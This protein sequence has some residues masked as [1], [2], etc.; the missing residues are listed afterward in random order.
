MPRPGGAAD[1]PPFEYWATPVEPGRTLVEASAGTGKTFAI[2]GLVLRLVLEGEWLG[3]APDLRRLLVVTFTNAATDELRT[4]VRAALRQALAVARGQVEPD[5]LTRPLAELLARDGAEGRLLA[6]LDRVDEAG[7][8]TIHGFCRRVLEQAAFESGTP[9]DLDFV[10]DADSAALRARAAADAWARLTHANPLLTALA[11]HHGRTPDALVAHHAAVADFPHVRVLPEAPDLDAA[12]DAL[13]EARAALDAAWDAD[14][15]GALLGALDWNQDAPL[16]GPGGADVLRRVAAFAGGAEPDAIAAVALCTAEAVQKKATTRSKAQKAAVAAALAHPALAACEAVM[17]AARAVDLAFVR[18]FIVEVEDQIEA[19]KERR[20]QLTFG[21]LITRLHDALHDR[22]TGPALAET[23]GRQFSVALIDEFQDTDPLQYAIFKTAFAGRPLYFVGD[24]KQAIYAFRGA[25]VHAYLG[26][27]READRR[28]TLGT[29][30]RSAAG[31][32]DAVNAVFARPERAFLFD[33]IPFRPVQAARREPALQDGGATPPLVWWPMPT[34][35]DG[36]PMGKGAVQAEI[37]AFVAAEVRRLLAEARLGD[38]ALEP[39]DIAV[40]V[41]TRFQA[42]DVQ[43]AL[44]GVGVPSVVSRSNDVRDSAAMA[45]VELVLRAVLR[46][47]DERARRAALSTELW[48]WTAREIAGLDDD[49][50][51]DAAVAGRL[52]EWQRMWRRG[53]VL[54]VLVAFQEAEGVL[55]R[56]L[57]RPDGERWATDLRHTAELL[58][59]IE[60]AGARSPDDL[61]HWLR[62]R[63]EQ[64]LPSRGM[65]ELR[66][67]RDAAAV[68]IT[69]HHNAKGLEYEV[70]F[71][72]YLWAVSERAYKRQDPVLARTPDGVVYDLGSPE[73][74]DHDR[75]RQADA[76]AEGVRTAYVAL[77]RARERCYVVWGPVTSWRTRVDNV[78][79]L[80]YLLCGHDAERGGGLADHVE[81]ARKRAAQ[82]DVLAP[83]HALDPTGRLMAVVDPPSLDDAAP[84]AP[85]AAARGGAAL[86]LPDDARRRLDSPWKRASFTAWTAGRDADGRGGGL[87]ASDEPAAPPEARADAEPTGLHAFAAGAGPGTCLHEVLQYAKW[88]DDEDAAEANR[89]TVA[90][91]LERHGLALPRRHRA[92]IDPAAEVLALVERVAT[93]PLLGGVALRD[94][95]AAALAPEWDFTLPLARVAPGA[96]ADVFRSHGAA[97]F[98]ADYADALSRLSPAA[99]DG[100]LVGS[101]DLVALADDRWWVV[102]WKSNRLG[103][104]ASAYAPDALQATML[105]HHYGLQLHLYTLGLHRYLRSRLGAAYAYETHVGGAA[106]AFL[107]GLG[108]AATPPDDAD[109]AGR[110]GAAGLFRHRPSAAL[111]EALDGLLAG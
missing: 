77:T 25:D 96:L 63:T 18:R 28:F 26:A 89:E 24:P 66:L 104:D 109:D 62:H 52:R 8:F 93:A 46:A 101:A 79:S 100:F 16:D 92:R 53:G 44:Q 2:A 39:G 103:A 11:L 111:V 40:L 47:G 55:D 9:F 61:L 29:N 67:E 1:V 31:L 73:A 3:A 90:R 30:W 23:I 76:L 49:P 36:K 37:P 33:D 60:R 5:D 74:D 57:A 87:A 21:D 82:D 20:G 17:E 59:E 7:I 80:G 64:A 15:V 19:I 65:K 48:G 99:V 108:G 4:R 42:N 81:A 32:V 22:A 54:G 78:S 58:H 110:G 107:R 94:V 27:Q 102:D 72:P 6:A 85:P 35:E 41:P 68:T 43:A 12:L 84:P 69:T 13:A 106:Y 51:T 50:E 97:P 71:L 56:L 75:L 91:R 38:R 70:V 105:E 14:A 45:D 95:E 98:G 83:L 86:A 10:E 34:K 88:G